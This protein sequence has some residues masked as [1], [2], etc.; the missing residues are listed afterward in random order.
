MQFTHPDGE[1]AKEK[2]TVVGPRYNNTGDSGH[3]DLK[4]VS[5]HLLMQACNNPAAEEK[6][7]I[8]LDWEKWVQ[9]FVSFS[10][11]STNKP[12]WRQMVE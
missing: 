3:T 4:H 10:E 12:T 9:M 5:Q 6:K 11:L 2:V 1:G 8:A 7:L